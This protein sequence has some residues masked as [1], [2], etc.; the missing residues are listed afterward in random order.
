[1]YVFNAWPPNYSSYLQTSSESLWF[2]YQATVFSIFCQP[3]VCTSLCFDITC[4][5]NKVPFWSL[6]SK[7]KFPFQHY[8]G[9]KLAFLNYIIWHLR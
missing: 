7:L 1:M 2:A 3:S 4:S 5:K 9:S 6:P 8:K